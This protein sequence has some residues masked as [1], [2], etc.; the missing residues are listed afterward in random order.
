[1]VECG[2]GRGKQVLVSHRKKG[3]G[4]GHGCSRADGDVRWTPSL[5]AQQL[6]LLQVAVLLLEDVSLAF[7]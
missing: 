4:G 3:V 1:M 6:L 7:L 2:G 5:F